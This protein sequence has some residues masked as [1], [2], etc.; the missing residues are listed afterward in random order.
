MTKFDTAEYEDLQDALEEDIDV[1]ASLPE[2]L[3]RIDSTVHFEC[4]PTAFVKVE[5]SRGSPLWVGPDGVA[6]EMTRDAALCPPGVKT[7]VAEHPATTNPTTPAYFVVMLCPEI[8]TQTPGRPKMWA[9]LVGTEL[10]DTRP[11]VDIQDNLLWLGM[12]I[13]SLRQNVLSVWMGRIVLLI[14]GVQYSDRIYSGLRR[15][16]DPAKC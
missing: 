15:L 11:V 2:D 13:D 10:E 12:H 3:Q 1:D 8:L 16:V 7:R 4:D 9:T 14:M 6:V 5:S